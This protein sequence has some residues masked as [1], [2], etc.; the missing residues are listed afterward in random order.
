MSPL[1]ESLSASAS[2][3]TPETPRLEICTISNSTEG[4]LRI[5]DCLT[6]LPPHRRTDFN[7]TEALSALH[8]ATI[9]KGKFDL[10]LVAFD[11]DDNTLPSNAQQVV[12][13]CAEKAR[14]LVLLAQES[15][16]ARLTLPRNG[17]V[18]PAGTRK[19]PPELF[20]APAE[21]KT[22]A[23]GTPPA[24]APAKSSR[25]RL[26]NFL[27]PGKIADATPP[28]DIL[29]EKLSQRAATIAFQGLAGG[30]GT[31]TLSVA[32]ATELARAR[33][34][35]TICLL[36][37]NLQF[38]S[39]A[40]Y[41]SLRESPRIDDAYRSVLSLDADNF[42]ECLLPLK[43][44]LFVFSSPQDI[45][46]P[47][48]LT[49]AAVKHLLSLARQRAAVVIVDTPHV[50]TDWTG[51]LYET[52]D[53]VICVLEQQV[54]CIHNARKLHE[55]LRSD[56]M[57]TRHFTY[58][59]NRAP[60]QPPPDWPETFSSLETGLDN[61]IAHVFP[62]GGPEVSEACD[63]GTPLLTAHPDNPFR[64]SIR[65]LISA[66]EPAPQRTPGHVS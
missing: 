28:A 52:A 34:S 30:V 55:L 23:P 13:L 63:L 43:K 61:R 49:G 53:T 35:D 27:R 12:T 66:A 50:L 58:A 24:T 2:S 21:G 10:A 36:D 37:L 18:L 20:T 5:A 40:C 9:E 32:F 1:G 15:A 48:A 16:A 60:I 62:D 3:E 7:M 65:A 29:Q 46:P 26:W 56:G 8:N 22:P 45:L 38:G 44:N 11:T 19:L 51:D 39:A 64:K 47:D 4:V 33:P 57:D 54:R 42:E 25:K 6:A 41:L 31:T 14:K 17:H 59:L